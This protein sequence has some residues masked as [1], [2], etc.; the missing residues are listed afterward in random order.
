VLGAVAG[1]TSAAHA[2][3]FAVR[4]QSA[5][6]QGSSFAGNAAGGALSSM[7]WNPAAIGQFNGINTESTY[8]WIIPDSEIT[9]LPGSTLIGVGAESGNIGNQAIVPSSYLSYQ[10]TPS[11]VLGFS[12]GAP[13]GLS[14]EPSNRV[15]AGMTQARTSKI[16]TYNLQSALAWRVTPTFIVAAGL[17]IERMEGTLKAA[18][19]PLATSR[20]GVIH[21]D[22][23]A[24]GWT[25]GALWH[26]TPTTTLGLG[27]R[28]SIEHNLEGTASVAGT[29][30][31]N[32]IEAGLK[33][34]ETV[35]LSLR[36]ELGSRWTGLASIEWSNWSRLKQ[37][38]VECTSAVCIAGLN[39]TLPLGWHDGWFYSLG[40]EYAWSPA[41]TL[42]GGVAYEVSPIQSAD[43][44]PARLPDS[45]RI[46]ASLGATYKWSEKISVDFAYSHIFVEDSSILRTDGGVLLVADAE[47]SV[48]ILSVGLKIK[49]GD[50]PP[51]PPLK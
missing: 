9:A 12:F 41:L 14:T 3:G 46:W 35:T 16:E 22:D 23:T 44:R 11:V 36:Q 42:R 45:D 6:F 21:G 18:T 38:Q 33:T 39:P 10:L 28:S 49:L 25:L 15:W 34:P 47:S 50:D 20:N 48:D 40:A 13:F 30:I 31:G 4:E 7:F 1:A 26:A 19:G 8:A 43:E 51:P 37:L 17:Q 29:P 2:G 32:N 5:H 24:F 27:F